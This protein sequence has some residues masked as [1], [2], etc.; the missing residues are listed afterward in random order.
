M[1]YSVIGVCSKVSIF[2]TV[3]ITALAFVSSACAAQQA[4]QDVERL[5]LDQIA[6]ETA[7]QDVRAGSESLAR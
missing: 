1:N 4:R 2:R 6:A 5:D 3:V 7:A